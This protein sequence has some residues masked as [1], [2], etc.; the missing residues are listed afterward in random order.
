[1]KNSKHFF[2]AIGVFFSCTAYAGGKLQLAEKA[3]LGAKA[4]P[5]AAPTIT[6]VSPK[7]L[8]DGVKA[9]ATSASVTRNAKIQQDAD[10]MANRWMGKK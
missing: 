8:M 6:F 4:A 3:L 10:M 5:K 2:C 9:R 1:M 7:S